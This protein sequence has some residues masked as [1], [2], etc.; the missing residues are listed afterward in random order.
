MPRSLCIM[1]TFRCTAQC[2]HCG[3]LSHPREETRLSSELIGRTIRQA[4]AAG[5]EEVVFSGG[6]PTLAGPTLLAAMRLGHA[7][8]LAV[9]MVTNAHWACTREDAERALDDYV[10]CGVAHLTLSTGDQHARFVP[11][12]SVLNAAR[13]CASRGVP[14]TIVVEATADRLI[15]RDRVQQHPEFTALGRAF[16]DASIEITE[17]AWTPLSPFRLGRYEDGVAIG[18]DNLAGCGGCSDI[19]STTTVQADGTIN[20][21]CGLAIRIV[22]ELNLGNISDTSLA[23]ADARAGADMLKR[24][25][26]IEGPERILAWA[27]THHPEIRWENRYAHKCQAC[28]RVFRDP[29]VRRAILTRGR[30]KLAELELM[31]TLLDPSP[32]DPSPTDPSPTDPSPTDPSRT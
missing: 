26:R 11:L 22:P 20:P 25:I 13:A 9:R 29:V 14:A 31:E 7:L 12:E 17:S 23:E 24:W 5:Y 16:P 30:E 19:F 28:M 1:P 32:T 8:G 4:A 2:R 6:E 10:G 3:T 18:R 15:T 27:E 21:C